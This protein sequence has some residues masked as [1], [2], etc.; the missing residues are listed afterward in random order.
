MAPASHSPLEAG[1]YKRADSKNANEGGIVYGTRRYEF[2]S[3]PILLRYFRVGHTD[4]IVILVGDAVT[5]AILC[6]EQTYR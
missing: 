3:D 2:S 6:G 4:A 1:N 5:G